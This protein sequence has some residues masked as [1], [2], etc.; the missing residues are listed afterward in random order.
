MGRM[1]YLIKKI[2]YYIK[3]SKS[4]NLTDNSLHLVWWDNWEVI[5]V[6]KHVASDG[7]SN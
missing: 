1:I 4:V 3:H 2:R 7:T 5:G 6:A